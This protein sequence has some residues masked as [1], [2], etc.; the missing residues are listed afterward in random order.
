M[1]KLHGL[2]DGD[3]DEL[4]ELTNSTNRITYNTSPDIEVGDEVSVRIN[5]TGDMDKCEQIPGTVVGMHA[6]YGLWE[7]FIVYYY[8]G[9]TMPCTESLLKLVKKGT[10][11]GRKRFSLIDD[12]VGGPGGGKVRTLRPVLTRQISGYQ[13]PNKFVPPSGICFGD[14]EKLG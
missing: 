1:G 9:R 14:A 12:R 10:Q 7:C 3:N 5:S 13:G 11:S 8:P 4:G 6:R 2:S